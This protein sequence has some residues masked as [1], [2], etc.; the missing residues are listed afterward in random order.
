MEVSMHSELET[1]TARQKLSSNL[2]VVYCNVLVFM[3]AT[4]HAVLP[5]PS[6][7]MPVRIHHQFFDRHPTSLGAEAHVQ[8]G[9]AHRHLEACWTAHFAGDRH[10]AVELQDQREGHKVFV[11]K[12]FSFS[13]ERLEIVLKGSGEGE[14]ATNRIEAL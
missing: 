11:R 1:K 7:I 10:P 8:A 4:G 2:S 5:R 14:T 9:D 3:M 6:L 12:F 13:T